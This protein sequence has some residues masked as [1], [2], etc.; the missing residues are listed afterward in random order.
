MADKVMEVT[1]ANIASI[2]G[3]SPP[4]ANAEVAQLRNEVSR[5]A[6]LIESM[7]TRRPRERSAS[8]HHRSPTPNTQPPDP[9]DQLCWYHAKFGEG[10]KKCK[11]PCS[12][13]LNP[14]AGH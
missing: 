4:A 2:H 3:N 6:T 14:Q 8:K 12:W 13:R 5:L 7:S 11:E 1:T 9:Q 10:A